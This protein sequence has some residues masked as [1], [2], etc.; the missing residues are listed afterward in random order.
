VRFARVLGTPLTFERREPLLGIDL[1]LE[2]RQESGAGRR[3]SG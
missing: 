2:A 3:G 1:L